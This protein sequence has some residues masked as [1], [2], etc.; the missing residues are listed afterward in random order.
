M[1]HGRRFLLVSLLLITVAPLRGA[2]AQEAPGPGSRLLRQPD[3]NGRQ[4]V[5]TYGGDIWV[6]DLSGGEARRLTS[7][8][9]VESNPV[10]SP[11]GRSIAFTSNRSGVPMVYVVPVVG[12]NPTRL[13]WYPSASYVRGWTPDGKRVLYASSRE[14][15]PV[16]FE[17]LWTV[18]AAGGPSDRLPAPWGHDGAYSPDGKKLVVDR[19]T[20]W[21]VEW[22]HYRG[23]QNT[24]LTILDLSDLSEIRLSNERTMDLHPVWMGAM[25]YFLSDRDGIMN[26]WSYNPTGGVLKQLTHFPETDVKW[27][28]GHSGTLVF[29]YEGRIHTLDPATGKTG[30]SDIKVSGDFPWAEPRWEDVA[31]RVA[32]VSL[33]PTGKR[34]LIEARGEIFTVPVEKGDTRNLTRSSGAADRA[35]VWSPRGD[36]VA[37]FSD[38]GSGYELLIGSQ[39]G[40]KPPRRLAITPSKMVWEV[41]WSPDA[42]RIAFVDD[43]VHIRVIEIASGKAV[44]VD[45]G[46]ANVER[47]DMGLTW[48][49]DSKWLAYAKTFPNKLRRIVLWSRDGAPRP[50][51]DPMADAMSPAWDRDGKHLYFLA[52]TD[53]ALGSGWANTSSINADPTFGAYVATLS[54]DESSP[55]SPESDDE[56]VSK[57]GEAAKDAGGKDAKAGASTPETSKAASSPAKS[58]KTADAAAGAGKPA[59]AASGEKAE[60]GPSKAVEV[61]VAFAGIERRIEAL[62]M[63]VSRYR[64]MVSGPAG[65]VFIGER[66]PPARSATLHK[67]TLEKRKSEKFVEDV[68]DVSVSSDGKKILFRRADKVFVGDTAKAPDA[69]KGEVKL[70]LQT[71]LDRAA[72]WRQIF[73]E[74]WHYERDFFY[75]PN[76][77]GADWTAVRKRYEPLVPFVRH[78]DDL[79]YILDQVNGELSVGHSFVF[80]GDMPE[81]EKPSGGL[82]GAD[83]EKD[84]GRWRIARIY[85]FE[86][87]NPKLTAPLDRPGLKVSKG[88]YI[89]S[90]N[91][92]ELTDQDD[93]YRLLDG[94]SKHQT[95]LQINDRPTLEGAWSVTVEPTDSESALRQRAWV[96]DN[97]RVVDELSGGKLAYVWVPN[98]GEPGV[99]SFNRYFFA[100]QDKLGAVID[101]RFNGG[102]NLDDY[103]VDLMTR[104]LRAAITNEVPD[105]KPFALPAG[106]LGPKVL[107]INERAGSGG[108]F[109][110]WV[111]RHQGAGPLIGART[112]GGLVKSSVHYPLVDGGGVTAPDNAVFDPVKREWIAENMGIAPDIEVLLDAKSAAAGKDPQLERGV[113]E[114]LRLL[115][116]QPPTNLA[117]PPYSKPAGRR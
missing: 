4:V 68:G 106:I 42:S 38:S 12:G 66:V 19:V 94:T 58:E 3:V 14:T 39:D 24:P 43:E 107:L 56:S 8:P 61:R 33:S 15:A 13:T 91:G 30:V 76:L 41:T 97:R 112:W 111:F 89:L 65:S 92:I 37:W 60:G 86:S 95:V 21:D 53:V 88:N 99:V 29:E 35:P 40:L 5:F 44:T 46:G 20:R 55:F 79:N 64:F 62:P 2:A 73:Q 9:A 98:T 93:P 80:G 18:P 45:T 54:S 83:F 101:E 102:G 103:M 49:P 7:T 36:D 116:Q 34:V 48:S 110:P 70:S 59:G 74:T 113:A 51:T 84:G 28:S 52:S 63:P 115:A 117:P 16:G 25:V 10:F 87:W 82:L 11:D 23:G 22:R 71:Y 27:L 67:F 57:E 81:V 109:F 85:T 31:K 69:G 32:S 6:A 96:E 100:Q 77:H 1:T 50:T 105:G 47:G 75:D 17:R 108:D 78:R 72:E 114:A 104:K 26:V 90:V